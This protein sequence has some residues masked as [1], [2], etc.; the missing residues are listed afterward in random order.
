MSKENYLSAKIIL[1]AKILL[2]HLRSDV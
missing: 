2:F 1:A